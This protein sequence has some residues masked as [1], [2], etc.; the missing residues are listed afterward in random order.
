MLGGAALAAP[1]APV[2][3]KAG[4]EGYRLIFSDSLLGGGQV[5]KTFKPKAGSI[6]DVVAH[7]RECKDFKFEEICTK[8]QVDKKGM[9]P[10]GNG[11]YI[12]G[13][14]GPLRR[15]LRTDAD[16]ENFFHQE[17][18]ATPM[19][20]VEV[21]LVNARMR[22]SVDEG[23]AL[24]A[25]EAKP[26]VDRQELLE[27]ENEKLRAAALKTDRD[28]KE[29]ERKLS[30]TYEHAEAIVSSL[31]H[32]IFAKFKEGKDDVSA[33]FSKL[34]HLADETRTE[35]ASTKAHLAKVEKVDKEGYDYLFKE[36]AALTNSTQ[37]R[38]EDVDREVQDLKLRDH[39]LSEEDQ[40]IYE[41]HKGFK[42]QTEAELK[43]IAAE[44]EER[45]KSTE[46]HTNATMQQ[47]FEQASSNLVAAKQDFDAQLKTLRE[48]L[49]AADAALDKWVHETNDATVKR[50]DEA[51]KQ[52]NEK[53]DEGF[54]RSDVE[55]G[56]LS[57]KTGASLKDEVEALSVSLNKD[58]QE[59]AHKITVNDGTIHRRA[60]GLTQQTEKTF[61]E[62]QERLE[63]MGRIERQRLAN[64]EKNFTEVLAKTR[65]DFRIDVER[66]RGDTDQEQARLDQDLTDLHTK[67]DL[68][69]QEINFFQS[70]LR[71]LKDWSQRSLNEVATATRAAGVD[72]Q[73]GL[74]ASQKMLHALRDDAVNFREKMA[75]YVSLLQH[76]SDS[77]SD[78]IASIE[79]QRFRARLELDAL[80]KDHTSYTS[81]MDGWADDVRVKVERLFR[82]LEPYK[83]Q[84]VIK[85]AGQ[86]LRNLK[87][88]LAVKSK[89]FTVKG[90]RGASMEFYPHGTN[91]S[92]EG[93]AVVRLL[94]PPGGHVRFQ[95]LLGKDTEGSKEFNGTGNMLTLDLFFD[96]WKDQ[97]KEDGSLILG[98]DILQ[99]FHNSDETLSPQINIETCG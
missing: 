72:S 61:K 63:E 76:S 99:D 62:F 14:D 2:V 78:A 26:K 44:A 16:V 39:E 22:P 98:L 81:D 87:K 33:K 47:G 96:S 13:I 60:D 88:P 19:P 10:N 21:E 5:V 11:I 74:Q 4:D 32:E 23:E 31:R 66:L 90:V 41:E 45:R 38:F 59:L 50:F 1:A 80:I 64:M 29:L 89:S 7:L 71:D 94:M 15:P 79:Q 35:L 49:V 12:H 52:L 8:R 40:R 68:T 42:L 48:D 36:S 92:P 97:I 69:K 95:C 73:E 25:V 27:D 93:K 77:H 57:K 54:S 70:K 53:V 67:H 51:G 84:W 55:L 46:S 9:S 34:H 28:L 18:R 82:A 91:T 30:N 17:K 58:V 6:R 37:E 24:P 65:S 56:K 85:Q 20:S 43:R 3:K 75:K 86:R 83:A